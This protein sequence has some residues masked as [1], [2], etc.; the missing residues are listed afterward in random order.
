MPERVASATVITTAV[1]VI[2]D[3]VYA[4]PSSLPPISLYF[5]VVFK[6]CVQLGCL[7]VG[8]GIRLPHYYSSLYLN[9]PPSKVDW[10]GILSPILNK[11]Q[12]M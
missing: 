5:I 1:D 9:F 10:V 6:V 8:L 11:E 12:R 7:G 2:L 3:I 4:A